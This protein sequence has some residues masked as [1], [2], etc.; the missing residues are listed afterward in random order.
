MAFDFHEKLLAIK[1]VI[2]VANTGTISVQQHPNKCKVWFEESQS[3]S[4][5]QEMFLKP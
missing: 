4:E 1:R 2:Q 5:A 3:I